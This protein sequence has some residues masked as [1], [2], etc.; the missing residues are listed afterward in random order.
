M[1]L[2]FT[3]P[4][5]SLSW[6]SFGVQ[7]TLSEKWLCTEIASI[8]FVSQTVDFYQMSVLRTSQA[9]I[10]LLSST[11]LTAK[12][13]Q[14][15]NASSAE[16]FHRKLRAETLSTLPILQ[17]SVSPQITFEQ[18]KHILPC[19]H[20]QNTNLTALKRG[21]SATIMT[22]NYKKW[23]VPCEKQHSGFFGYSIASCQTGRTTSLLLQ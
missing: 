11:M 5:E 16:S 21:T 12:R 17:S 20:S 9:S 4:C 3:P 2:H 7:E 23:T 1:T 8:Q 14:K 15:F 19:L 10:D 18:L 6:F 13:N 22:A